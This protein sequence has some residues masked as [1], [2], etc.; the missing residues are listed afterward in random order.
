MCG[1]RDRET[2]RHRERERTDG[3]VWIATGNGK[4]NEGNGPTKLS[5]QLAICHQVL[6][7]FKEKDSSIYFPNELR[8]N[9]AA[10]WKVGKS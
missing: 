3:R 1:V 4:K 8:V 10:I 2:E 9:S 5:F 6:I 7:N